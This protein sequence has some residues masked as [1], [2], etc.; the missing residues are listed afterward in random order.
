V[1]GDHAG[2]I[3]EAGNIPLPAIALAPPGAGAVYGALGD[4]R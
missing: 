4:D 3:A 2:P 1:P